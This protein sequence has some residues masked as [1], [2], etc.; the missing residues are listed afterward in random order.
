MDNIINQDQIMGIFRVAVPTAL[1]WAVGKGY[2]PA[3]SSADIGTGVLAIAAAVWSYYAHS[4]QAKI[5]AVT[6]LPDVKKIVTVTNPVSTEIK[7][8]M[9]DA[10]QPK[11]TAGP[12]V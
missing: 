8:A 4:T 11:V 5:N 1:A 10:T 6:A 2:I 12:V 9:A 7:Q 3:G